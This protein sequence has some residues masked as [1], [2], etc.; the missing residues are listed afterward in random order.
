[1]GPYKNIDEAMDVTEV[2]TTNGYLPI[3]SCPMV[4]RGR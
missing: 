4:A 1:M 2:Y 3:E